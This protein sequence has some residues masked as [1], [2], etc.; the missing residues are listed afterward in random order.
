MES[1]TVAIVGLHVGVALVFLAVAAWNLVH[2][3]V[4]GAVLQSV[5]GALIAVLGVGI[6]RAA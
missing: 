5:L 2:G 6:A 4:V 1:R 3:D